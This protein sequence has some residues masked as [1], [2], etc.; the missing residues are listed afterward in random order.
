MLSK[1][2]A[3]VILAMSI[4]GYLFY[5][6]VHKPLLG[7]MKQQA[8]VIAAQEIRQ[9]EQIKTLEALQANFIKTTEALNVMSAKNAEIEAEQARYLGIFK[10][11]N[12]TKLAAA[13]PGLI[14][15]RINRGTK[16]VFDSIENDSTFID[17]LDE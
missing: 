16:N 11:H 17:S 8:A 5:T 9:Q 14:T 6:Q 4:T 1:L 10:R 12:L 15:T 7:E 3:G 13:K 2:F